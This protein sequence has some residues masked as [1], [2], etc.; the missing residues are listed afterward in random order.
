VRPPVAGART[1]ETLEGAFPGAGYAQSIARAPVE[2]EEEWC[3]FAG[4]SPRL[5]E[6]SPIGGSGER[7]GDPDGPHSHSTIVL[8]LVLNMVLLMGAFA[9]YPI[10]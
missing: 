2:F 7:R 8:I 10:Y 1:T 4:G 3:E 5:G 6:Q 9:E